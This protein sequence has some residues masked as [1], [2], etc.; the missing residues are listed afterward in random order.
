MSGC[1]FFYIKTPYN[2]QMRVKG[3]PKD[4]QRAPKGITIPP[5]SIMGER[6][7][8][9]VGENDSLQV[10]VRFSRVIRTKK[11]QTVDIQLVTQVFG[12]QNKNTKLIKRDGGK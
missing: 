7:F 4:C 5:I 8:L 6:E 12:I 2:A 10:R 11:K 9:S 1:S 3:L